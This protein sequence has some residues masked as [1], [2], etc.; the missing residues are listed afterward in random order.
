[1]PQK[2]LSKTERRKQIIEVAMDLFASKGFKGTTTRAIAESAGVSEAIIFRHFATKEKLYDAIITASLEKRMAIW[3]RAIP[4]TRSGIGLEELMRTYARVFLELNRKDQTFIRLM[5]Y[6]ALEDHKFRQRFFESNRTPYLRSIRALIATGVESGEYEPVDPA[7]TTTSFFW[8]LLQYCIS[9]FVASKDPPD[10]S[11]DKEL[12]D[13]LVSV[14]LR[15][16]RKSHS[17]ST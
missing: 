8:T 14:T 2:R 13:N 3:E 9:R 11:S 12:I 1:M 5:M 10:P 4:S 16:L 15:G 6:S 7:L 17:A